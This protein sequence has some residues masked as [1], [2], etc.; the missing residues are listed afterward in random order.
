MMNE[1]ACYWCQAKTHSSSELAIFSISSYN[2]CETES[3]QKREY[4][5][6]WRINRTF[7]PEPIVHKSAGLKPPCSKA[8]KCLKVRWEAMG[9]PRLIILI[10]DVIDSIEVS[11]KGNSSETG[12]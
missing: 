7:Q 8:L 5:D 11:Q 10:P 6:T 4:F 1:G 12:T 2:Y 3:P 9:N